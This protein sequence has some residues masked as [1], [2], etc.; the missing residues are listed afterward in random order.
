MS[1]WGHLVLAFL[2]L[3]GAWHEGVHVFEHAVAA[4]CSAGV[5]GHGHDHDHDHDHGEPQST[6]GLQ[7]GE[8]LAASGH[9]ELHCA[10]CYLPWSPTT[11]SSR[12]GVFEP[13]QRDCSWAQSPISIA[14]ANRGGLPPLRGPPVA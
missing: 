14:A 4:P 9:A 12:V 11:D 2:V 10:A 6:P 13:L 5:H 1:R 8:Q 7:P 3:L